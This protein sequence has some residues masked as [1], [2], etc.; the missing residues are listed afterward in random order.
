MVTRGDVTRGAPPRLEHVSALNLIELDFEGKRAVIEAWREYLGHL[1]TSGSDNPMQWVRVRDDRLRKLLQE[2]AKVLRYGATP[3]VDHAASY[4]PVAHFDAAGV[5]ART[6]KAL[7]DVLEGKQAIIIAS[8][9]QPAQAPQLPPE[10]P[11][12]S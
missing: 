5:Q 4:L 10:D 7:L 1:N 11:T 8:Q 9:A 6:S 2:M 12:K 3:S